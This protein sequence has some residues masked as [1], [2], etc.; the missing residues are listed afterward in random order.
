MEFVYD[1]PLGVSDD[2]QGNFVDTLC[3]LGVFSS[4]NEAGTFLEK[5]D[6]YIE[7]SILTYDW[8]K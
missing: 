8:F 1:E 4:W 5:L 6:D 7:E 3:R 2:P